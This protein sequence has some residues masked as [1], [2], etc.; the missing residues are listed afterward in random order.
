MSVHATTCHYMP[1][2]VNK[3]DYTTCHYI[4]VIHLIFRCFVAFLQFFTFF[5]FLCDVV[6]LHTKPQHALGYFMI[7]HLTHYK[8]SLY[9]KCILLYYKKIQCDNL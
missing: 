1:V 7:L 9:L 6:L 8:N 2:H 4:I 3:N 5:I